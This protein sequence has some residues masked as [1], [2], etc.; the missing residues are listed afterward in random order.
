M[1]PTTIRNELIK[2]ARDRSRASLD[3]H[4]AKLVLEGF[5]VSIPRGCRVSIADTDLA[6]LDNLNPPWALKIISPDIQHK[7]DGG[8]VALSLTD[9]DR[10]RQEIEN[11]SGRALESGCAVDGFLV[12]EMAN[13]GIEIIIG[14]FNDACFGPAIMFGLGGVFVEVLGDVAFRVCPINH[15]DAEDMIDELVGRRIFEG[16]RGGVKADRQTLV[17][18]LLAVGGEDGLIVTMNSEIEEIDLN[19]IIVNGDQATV[20]DAVMILRKQGNTS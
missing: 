12:E 13:P 16:A 5:R 11:M 17:E 20:V 7:S 19:P 9:K 15:L 18:L 1:Q 8:F 2:A 4:S 10:V 6:Q 3:E 14:G